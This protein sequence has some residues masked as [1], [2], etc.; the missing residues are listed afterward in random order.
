[1][2]GQSVG[3]DLAKRFRGR[4]GFRFREFGLRRKIPLSRGQSS[5]RTGILGGL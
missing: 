3:S 4:L 5:S 2:T 1:M